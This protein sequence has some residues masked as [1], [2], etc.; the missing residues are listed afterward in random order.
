MKVNILF[1]ISL[2]ASVICACQKEQTVSETPDG[3]KMIK[4]RAVFADGEL[5]SKAS[6]EKGQTQFEW[7]N[8]DKVVAWNGS[9]TQNCGITDIDSK[10]VATF[11][12]PEGTQWVIYPSAVLTV[13][14]ATATWTRPVPQTIAGSNQIVGDGANPMFG[15]VI[16]SEVEFTNLCGFIEFKFTGSKTLKKFS[17]KSNNMSSPAL[18]GKGTIDIN[19]P[20]PV[21][22]YPV[23][24][25][26]GT[27]GTNQ[28]GYTNVDG[29][30]L[31]LTTNEPVKVMVVLPPAT[32]EAAEIILEFT[33]GT[34]LAIISNYDLTVERNTVLKVKTI[35]VDSRFPDSPVALDASGRSNCYLVEAGNEP[36]AYSFEAASILDGTPF[37]LAKTA[38]MVWSE[39]KKLINNITYD[40]NSHRVTFLYN[41]ENR[42]G[43]ALIAIDQNLQNAATTLLWNYHIWVT[44]TPGDVIMDDSAMPAP[45]MDRNVGATWAPKSEAEVTNM[46]EK[47]W[48]ETVGTYYQYGNHIPYPR[49]ASMSNSSKAFDNNRIEIQYGFSNYCQKMATSSSVKNS[50]AE[51]EQMCNYE[52][53]KSTGVT[54][55][56]MNETIWTNYKIKGSTVGDGYEDI[57]KA[58]NKTKTKQSNYDPC[59]QGYVFIGATHLY[60]STTQN[61]ASNHSLE[62]NSAGK[63]HTNNSGDLLYYPAAGYFA[64]GKN[65]MVGGNSGA[66]V[67]YWSYYTGSDMNAGLFRRLLMNESDTAFSAGNVPFSSQAHNMRCARLL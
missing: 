35:D 47:Q 4:V 6:L 5:P 17:F 48:L 19:K 26:V 41:G 63:Y 33:D 43:N 31:Q 59:P 51:Q 30:N 58:P 34:A 50:L 11:E 57:W 60:R 3:P 66:R 39:D 14:D 10:G 61:P 56:N 54:I 21:L 62:G 65:Y 53:H 36:K 7:S 45:I 24:S 9:A 2:F 15:K 8:D 16:G 29:L 40:A 37:N 28:Y 1:S 55:S 18:T 27:S 32:Y 52:Y 46:T 38:N 67:V 64:Q 44:D 25:S 42:E 49:I 20:L 23:L 22:S 13:S 12:V